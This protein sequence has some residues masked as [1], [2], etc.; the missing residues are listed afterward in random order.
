MQVAT[1]LNKKVF[2]ENDKW[3]VLQCLDLKPSQRAL[4]TRNINE[5]GIHVMPMSHVRRRFV[6]RK[7]KT[8]Q[9]DEICL[10]RGT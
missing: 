3:N 7:R 2:L 4:L 8:S 1:V 10:Q 9:T 5:A 6:P